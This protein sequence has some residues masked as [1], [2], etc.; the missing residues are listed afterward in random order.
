MVTSTPAL[1]SSRERLPFVLPEF[2]RQS[3]VNESMRALWEPRIARI[4]RAWL[5]VEWRSVGA[6]ARE[7]GLMWI[8]PRDVSTLIPQ[9]QAAGLS[10]IQ[11]TESDRLEEK[12]TQ[13]K[14]R[15]AGMI[16]V[17]VGGLDKVQQLRQAW[18][19]A[20][21]ERVG[22]LLGYPTCCRLFFREVWVDQR[23]TDTTW[24]MAERTSPCDG[25]AIRIE[26]PEATPPFANILWRWLGV[27]AVPHLPCRFDC[28]ESISLGKRLLEIAESAGFAEEAGWI[29]EILAWPVE[30]SSLHGIA[31]V[32]SPLMKISTSTDATSG[33]WVVQWVGT[34]YPEGGA[35]GLRFPYQ[36]PRRKPVLTPLLTSPS[37]TLGAGP[38]WRFTDNGFPSAKVMDILHQPIVALAHAALNDN[39]GNV[40]DLGCGNGVL[41]AKV[42]AGSA[43]IPYG[44]D[45]NRSALE[46][47]RHLFPRFSDNFF[48]GDLFDVE[49]WDGG[50]RRY[51]LALLMLGRLLEVPEERAKTLLASLS[52]SSHRV[53]AYVYPDWSDR[54]LDA[55]A[56]HFGFETEESGYTT[57]AYLKLLN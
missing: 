6:G 5:D 53:L 49:L 41:L 2:T 57:A 16:C 38:A 39:G 42:C 7:C 55:I 24:A 54:S 36:A 33:K 56:Q 27:R 43:L 14:A 21:D 11:L 50:G 31:E 48:E 46:R 10:A 17:V 30:W 20:D 40:L 18:A 44:V 12:I 22:D 45:T 3:W 29:C 52:R 23:C 8:S 4:V 34:K 19:D 28:A 1:R 25:N 35:T 51:A 37:L 26:S 9:W 47:A 15:A 32:K 13:S